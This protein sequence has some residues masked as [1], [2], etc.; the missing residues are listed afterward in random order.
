[1]Y[2]NEKIME[3]VENVVE[4]SEAYVEFE[5]Y[6]ED[7]EIYVDVFKFYENEFYC[8]DLKEYNF[9]HVT[10]KLYYELVDKL[11][12]MVAK[13]EYYVP[14]KADTMGRGYCDFLELII[15]P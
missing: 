11:G 15:Y 5:E 8:E 6:A 14:T 2:K 3:I 13:I 9:V 10:S 4:N 7:N 12:D 1:M